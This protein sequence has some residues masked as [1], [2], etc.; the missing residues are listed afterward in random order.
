MSH[1]PMVDAAARRLPVILRRE[2]WPPCTVTLIYWDDTGFRCT[3][4]LPTGKYI[5][6]RKTLI[7]VPEV[8]A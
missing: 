4:Q 6:V 2:G 8:A 1:D 3:V 5:N 7:T